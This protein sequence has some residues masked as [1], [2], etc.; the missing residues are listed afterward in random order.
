MAVHLALAESLNEAPRPE[1]MIWGPQVRTA[2]AVWRT[3]LPSFLVVPLA[4]VKTII[5]P[6]GSKLGY[7]P[8]GRPAASGTQ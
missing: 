5:P 3:P 4:S 1:E 2:V 8:Q 6:V 7:D